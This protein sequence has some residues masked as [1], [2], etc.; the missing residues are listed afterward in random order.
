MLPLQAP[1]CHETY[2]KRSIDTALDKSQGSH[3]QLT[4]N[5]RRPGSIHLCSNSVASCREQLRD[6]RRLEPSFSQTECGT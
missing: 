3:R 1:E 2:S 4:D 6:T 5:V